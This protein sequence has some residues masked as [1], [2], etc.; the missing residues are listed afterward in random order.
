MHAGTLAVLAALEVGGNWR[1]GAAWRRAVSWWRS[2]RPL[3]GILILAAIAAPWLVLVHQ[4]APDFLPALLRRAGKYTSGGAEGHAEPPGYYLL[5]IWGTLFPWSLIL[6]AGIGT[7]IRNRS[8]PLMRFSLAAA[9]GPWLVMECVVNK[10]PFYILPSFPALAILIAQA[11]VRGIDS[12]PGKGDD[13]LKRPGFLAGVA[14]WAAATL[15]L[16]ALPFLAIEKIGGPMAF[17]L[18]WAVVGITYAAFVTVAWIRRR[19]RAASMAMAGGMAI[20]AALLFGL[21]L[22]NVACLTS[23]RT[24]GGQLQSLGAGGNTPVAMTDYREPSL[25]F[26]QGGGARESNLAD[27]SAANCPQWAVVSTQGFAK[28]S[29]DAQARYEILTTPLRTLIYNDG[30]YFVDL[31]VIRRN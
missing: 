13:D 12:E 20:L 18:A 5:I 10:L 1:T 31:I 7:A 9:I 4:R 23:S 14:I 28:L 26:Y 29:P 17:C 27:L 15:A 2:T 30:W 19:V 21:I 24:V 25:A 3:V 8:T 6:P 16:C 22:P 11:I